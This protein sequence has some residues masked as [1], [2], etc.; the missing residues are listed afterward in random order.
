MHST[1]DLPDLSFY[2]AV[3]RQ[4]RADIARY[5]MALEQ[6]D[7]ADVVRRQALARWAN[8]FG[9]E[10]VVHHTIEDEVFFPD[11]TMRVP[12]TR[13]TLERLAVDHEKVHH[14][15]GALRR[16]ARALAGPN[17]AV[18]RDALTGPDFLAA[19][20]DAIEV[21]VELRDL[22]HLHLDVEDEEI[23]SVFHRS[24]GRDEYEALERQATKHLPK[25]GLTFSIP[26]NVAAMDDAQRAEALATA[27]LPLRVLYRLTRKRFARL[28]AEAFGGISAPVAA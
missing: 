27:P 18:A 8:G 17:F 22:L 15:L 23:L 20:D 21:G 6:L 9:H 16:T 13:A 11:L 4:Q 24:Y 12:S 1:T 7:G 25:K 10:L 2:L 14:L 26:W 5:V 3:H 28:V 19:R